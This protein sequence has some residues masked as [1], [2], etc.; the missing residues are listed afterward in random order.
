M[1]ESRDHIAP[2][3]PSPPPARPAER[4]SPLGAPWRW[5]TRRWW[6]V[7]R[8]GLSPAK[9]VRRVT[10]RSEPRILCITIPKSGTHLL[11]RVLCLH[12][13]LYRKVVGTLG[14]PRLRRRGGFGA[15]LDTLRPGQIAVGHLAFRPERV[16]AIEERN[17]RCIFLVRDPRDMVVSRAFYVIKDP[18]HRLREHFR[19]EPDPA[20]RV[21]SAIAG[22]G[23][24]RSIDRILRE[25][26][27]WLDAGALVVR[28]EDLVGPAGGGDARRQE[29]TLRRIFA[30]VGVPT[31][32]AE[33]A[34]IQR[35]AFSE[36]SPTF[37][38][39]SIGDWRRYFDDATKELFSESVGDLL[40]RY[41][42]RLEADW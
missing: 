22:D 37:R 32:D 2:T 27:G 28:F 36:R 7:T 16:R 25:F 5:V 11:E 1:P 21:R 18:K 6:N 33:L 34:R 30:H 23:S 35:L 10:N 41:P 13:H 24:W 29:E 19:R 3:S 17:V 40:T 4:R 31:S 39:G 26:E 8:F 20:K 42:Y 14:E 12:P 15:M 9:L 38:R